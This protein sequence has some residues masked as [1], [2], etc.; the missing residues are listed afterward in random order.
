MFPPRSTR[1]AFLSIAGGASLAALAPS[2]ATRAEPSPELAAAAG[3]LEAALDRVQAARAAVRSVMT[4]VDAWE[5]ANPRP[6]SK[7]GARRWKR[8]AERVRYS[9]EVNAAWL[10][11]LNA[12]A[13]Y[14][15]A[16][17]AVSMIKAAD[18]VELT[19]KAALAA[20]YDRT[21]L[22]SGQMAVIAYGVV[23]DIVNLNGKAVL[24]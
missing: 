4:G 12:E 13:S 5:A 6:S 16:Q 15:R 7:R 21:E 17:H 9:S 23:V 18:I 2:T 19:F 8:A 11:Q 24:S 10:A 1:R 22:A 14:R 20:H 3:A